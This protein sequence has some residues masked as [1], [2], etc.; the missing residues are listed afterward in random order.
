M[1]SDLPLDKTR[2]VHIALKAEDLGGRKRRVS[3]SVRVESTIDRVW[4]VI[5]SY[6]KMHLY[7][8]NIVESTVQ[9]R[10]DAL[11]LDQIGVISRKLALKTRMLMRVTEDLAQRCITFSRVEGRDFSE[12]EGRYFLSE[13]NGQVIVGYDLV[14]VPFPLF[15]MWMIER[16]TFKEVPRMLAAIREEAILGRHIPFEES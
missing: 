11:Y 15:P 4:H 8:P 5:T 10:D 9:H 3:G 13:D 16:K 7:I 1:Q 2:Q 14:A 6:A 12:F